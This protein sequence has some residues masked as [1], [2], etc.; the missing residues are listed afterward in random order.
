[1]WLAGSNAAALLCIER[2]P[3]AGKIQPG[4][5]RD[6]AHPTASLLRVSALVHRQ[7][8]DPALGA[9]ANRIE[10]IG[11]RRLAGF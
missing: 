11:R 3:L 10:R 6:T 4:A 1:M 8:G 5:P 7:L 2:S 9:A